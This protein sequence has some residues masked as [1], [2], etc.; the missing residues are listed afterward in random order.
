MAKF[1]FKIE[2]Y[3]ENFRKVNEF[4]EWITA[5]EKLDAW[6]V[7]KNAYPSSKGYDV[8]LISIG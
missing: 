7:I 2:Q 3:N 1:N 8:E 4:E 5:N 6:A